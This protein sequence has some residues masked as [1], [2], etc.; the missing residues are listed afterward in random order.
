MR[1][2]RI[3]ILPDEGWERLVVL[4]ELYIHHC[5]ELKSLP[6]KLELLPEGLGQLKK[7]TS[8]TISGAE[9]LT[10]LP[11]SLGQLESLEYLALRG[12]KRLEL[13]PEGLGQLKKL[14]WLTID[15]AEALTQLPDSVTLLESLESSEVM[16]SKKLESLPHSLKLESLPL[17]Q[18][19]A[20]S[21]CPLLLERCRREGGEDWYKNISHV[22]KI[23]IDNA[24]MR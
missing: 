21:N 12:L 5:H 7:L 6:N 14:T 17:L 1:S 13:L 20:I 8:L 10:Q 4:Q 2:L 24:R 18:Y 15:D 9:T 3:E 11:N 23:F 19:L 22:P 16:D